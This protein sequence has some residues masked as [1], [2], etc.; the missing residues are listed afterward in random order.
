MDQDLTA[1]LQSAPASAIVKPARITARDIER[2]AA[3]FLAWYSDTRPNHNDY[4]LLQTAVERGCIHIEEGRAI[5]VPI[6]PTDSVLTHRGVL[7]EQR[8][9]MLREQG[10]F[11]NPE[12]RHPTY[13]HGSGYIGEINAASAPHDQHVVLKISVPLL[14]ERRTIFIDPESIDEYMALGKSFFVCGGI[15]K[16]AIVDGWM[17]YK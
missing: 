11:G 5:L 16:E 3:T 13:L 15:P 8:L 14:L 2:P 17:P 4:P 6:I 12:R 9:A 10:V 1:L 7:D